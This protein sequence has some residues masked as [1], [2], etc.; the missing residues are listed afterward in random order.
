EHG[1]R[2]AAREEVRLDEEEAVLRFAA[3]GDEL[4]REPLAAAGERSA[5]IVPGARQAE[6]VEVER[7]DADVGDLARARRC[8]ASDLDPP[9]A[10]AFLDLDLDVEQ[11]RHASVD[12]SERGGLE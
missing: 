2:L 7:L 10:V 8:A 11:A 5:P 12:A 9:V 3:S 1:K 4:D 6:E